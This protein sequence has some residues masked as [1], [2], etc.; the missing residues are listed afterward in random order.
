MKAS[1][2]QARRLVGLRSPDGSESGLEAAV[3]AFNSVVLVLAGV[4]PRG[5]NQL[6]DHV[7]QRRRPVNDHLARETTNRQSS[8]EERTRRGNVPTP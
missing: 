8:R 4:V 2:H 5:P 7:R 3:I 1:D 6:L